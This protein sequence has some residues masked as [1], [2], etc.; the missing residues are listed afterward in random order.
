MAIQEQLAEMNILKEEPET[1]DYTANFSAY[2]EALNQG[3]DATAEL[4][5][6]E[7]D[8]ISDGEKEA[9][10]QAY[11]DA[12]KQ[13][14]TVTSNDTPNDSGKSLAEMMDDATPKF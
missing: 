2:M 10:L 6:T 4:K 11:L 12:L 14:Y 8:D 5:V 13:D 9:S 3:N 7:T 1:I